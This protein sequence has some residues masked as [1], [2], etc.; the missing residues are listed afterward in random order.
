MGPL[1][2][3]VTKPVGDA[4]SADESAEKSLAKSAK[5]QAEGFDS[6]SWATT[7]CYRESETQA[8]SLFGSILLPGPSQT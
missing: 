5:D 4:H 8:E 7:V 6:R 1:N 3:R 2:Q